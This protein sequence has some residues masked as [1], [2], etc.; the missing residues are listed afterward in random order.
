MYDI[1]VDSDEHRFYSNGILS[2]NSTSYSIFCL[3]YAL[4]NKEKSILICANKFKTAKDILGRIKMAYE[5]LP[6][7][8]KPGIVEWNAASIVFDNGC[9]ISAEATS[10]SSGRGGSINCLGGNEIITLLIN[11][12]VYN[13]PIKN[14][15]KYFNQNKDIKYLKR[16]LQQNS[17]YLDLSGF[18]KNS[19]KILSNNCWSKFDGIINNGKRNTIVANVNDCEIVCTPDHKIIVNNKQIE[20]NEFFVRNNKIENVY[21]VINVENENLFL[22]NNKILVHNCLV[23][24]EFAFLAPGLEDEFLQS[25][26]PVVSSS[27]TSKI[28][29]VSTPNGM[30]NEFYRIW[31][32]AELNLD[33]KE[34]DGKPKWKPVRV[35][36]WE[37]PG[38][39]EKW[40]EMQL[41]SF[42]RIGRKI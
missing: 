31:N 4:I 27:K 8:L 26:F 7:W 12:N 15:E 30:G 10:G 24:D 23:C 2:H 3:W 6:Q 38:R 28:I 40:K 17:K 39:D 32:R 33:V 20:A 5:E 34:D 14:A 19:I 42:G 29:I 41:E 36:W 37:V 13:I 11:G 1:H 21:D 16:F 22:V 9:K 18:D 25:V 35:N